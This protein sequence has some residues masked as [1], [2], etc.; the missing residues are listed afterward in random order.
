MARYTGP[1]RKLSRRSGTDLGHKTN[2]QKT[3]RRLNVLPGSH[4]RKG[5]SR[6]S[7]YALQLREKQKIKWAYGILENQF[8]RYYKIAAKTP[9]GTGRELLKLLER[10][11]DNVIYRLNFAPT[12]NAA[13]QL[14]THGHIKIDGKKVSIPSYLVKQDQTISLSDKAQK[15]PAIAELFT[16]KNVNIPKWLEKKAA[17]GRVKALPE[18]TDVDLDINEQ[19][20]VEFYSRS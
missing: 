10:R 17:V 12:R 18:R 5:T 7:D 4:G 13:R 20:I 8:R 3:A 9:A 2:T 15:I 1:T 6:L 16:T 14:V 11:L 19:L